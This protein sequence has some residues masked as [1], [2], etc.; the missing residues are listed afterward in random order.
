VVDERGEVV[1]GSWDIMVEVVEYPERAV[2][3]DLHNPV[4]NPN[5]LS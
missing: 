1:E 2:C 3:M 5:P 4:E